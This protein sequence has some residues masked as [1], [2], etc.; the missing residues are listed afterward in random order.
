LCDGLWVD[1]DAIFSHFSEGLL[2]Q[3]HYM[4]LIYVARLSH[5]FR[6]IA[7]KNYEKSKIGG[8]VCAHHFV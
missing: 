2:Y 7:V 1:F 4:V 8:N 3:V 6:E 5:N